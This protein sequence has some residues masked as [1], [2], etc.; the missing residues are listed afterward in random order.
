MCTKSQNIA[1][2]MTPQFSPHKAVTPNHS[3][4]IKSWLSTKQEIYPTGEALQ[5]ML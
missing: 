2:A 4:L 5:D 1:A 3:V